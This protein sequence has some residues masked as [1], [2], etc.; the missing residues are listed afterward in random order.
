MV[1]T[2]NAWTFCPSP[3]GCS[4]DN[5]TTLVERVGSLLHN[6]AACS[7][8]FM[9]GV[10]RRPAGQSC[11]DLQMTV[12]NHTGS[13]SFSLTLHLHCKGAH[14]TLCTFHAE[15][16]VENVPEAPGMMCRDSVS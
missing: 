7:S 14:I 2:C 8:H 15:L 5:G 1:Q 12:R 4:S 10:V 3:I 16:Q 9:Q 13:I 11:E 6:A